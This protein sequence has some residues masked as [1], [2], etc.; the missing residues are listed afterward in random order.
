MEKLV[1]TM[2][3]T[4]LLLI[5]SLAV[6]LPFQ[7]AVAQGTAP[8]QPN[9][10]A[11][12][13]V[14]LRPE[15]D[16]PS[17]LVIYHIVIS[18]E[19]KLPETLTIRIPAR[20]KQPNAAAWVDPADGN[21][22]DLKYTTQPSGEWIEVT[23]ISPGPEIQL[24]YYDPQLTKVG[25]QREYAYDWSGDFEIQNLSIHIEQPLGASN[26]SIK[27][28]LGSPQKGENGVY[29]YYAKLGSV[30]QGTSFSIQMQYDKAEDTLSIEQLKVSASGP[31]ND[32]TLGRS[33]LKEFMPWLTAVLFVIIISGGIWWFLS[34][35]QRKLNMVDSAEKRHKRTFKAIL[36]GEEDHNYC[37]ECGQR[38]ESGDLFCRICGTRLRK[39]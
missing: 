17:V 8:D 19:T 4:L 38:A 20:A 11:V 21:M 10:L 30:P 2:K 26:M 23:M 22:Y 28:N 29:Y 12:L 3:R 24:E 32:Q 7:S 18:A 31:L 14:D 5:F 37:H 1:R 25:T 27:P 13:E 6:L 34:F 36:D 33:T 9:T 39:V 35:N 15:F 16:E